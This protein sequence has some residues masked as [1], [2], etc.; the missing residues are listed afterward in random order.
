[1]NNALSVLKSEWQSFDPNHPLEF[2]FLDQKVQAQYGAETRL[3]RIFTLFSGLAVFISC[4]GLAGLISFTT[5]QRTKEIGIRKVL[6]ASAPTI[7]LMLSRGFSFLMLI[8]F[9]IAAP[10]AWYAMDVWLQNF[11]YHRPLEVTQFLLSGLLLLCIA[12]LTICYQT[13]RA[14]VANP[15]DAL[16][17]E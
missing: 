10:V 12:W 14:A 1:M 5:E 17:Y 3:L 13:I 16:R 2:A 11:A 4:L 9:F 15:V 6:G 7:V 8:A